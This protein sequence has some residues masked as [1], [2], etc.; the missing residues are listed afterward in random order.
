[1][2]VSCCPAVTRTVAV[3]NAA[4]LQA[5]LSGAQLGDNIVLDAGAT[6]EGNFIVSVPGGSAGWVTVSSSAAYALPSPGTRVGPSDAVHMAKIMSPSAGDSTGDKTR[7]ALGSDLNAT[8]LAA[9]GVHHYRFIGIEFATGLTAVNYG[10]VQF[11]PTNSSGQSSPSSQPHDIIF[12]RCLIHGNDP[13]ATTFPDGTAWLNHGVYLDA[14]NSAIVDSAVYNFWS[15]SQTDSQ[16]IFCG[17]G[18]GPRL[19]QNTL[20]SGGTE[21][22]LCGGAPLPYTNQ[23][24]T[25]ITIVHNYFTNPIAWRT[26]T[27]VIPYVKNRFELKVGQRVRITD[28][29]FEN[30][31]DRGNGQ[32]GYAVLLTPRPAQ[33]AN[34]VIGSPVLMSNVVDDI[35]LSNNVVRNVGAFLSTGLYDSQCISGAGSLPAGTPC[36]QSARL[37]VSD[38]MADYDAAI[39]P[40]SGLLFGFMQDF[41]VKRNTLLGHNSG[42]GLGQPSTWGNRDQSIGCSATFGTN[43]EFSYNILLQGVAGDCTFDPANILVSSWLG[44]DTVTSNLAANVSGAVLNDWTNFGHSSSIAATEASIGLASSELTLQGTSPYFGMGIGANLACFNEAA[45]RAGTPSALCPLPPEVAGGGSSPSVTGFKVLF[46]SQS[47]DAIGSS[48]TRLPWQITGI[49][50]TFSEPIT[51]GNAGSLAGIT[52]TG[53]SGL[54]TNT[55]T[56][57]F[58]PFALGIF[59]ANLA[60]TGPNALTDAAGHGLGSGAGFSQTLEVLWGDFNDDGS[61]NS[62]DQVLVNT[63]TR[64]PYNILADMNGDGVVNATDVLLVRSRIGTSLH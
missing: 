6:Y 4:D 21:G 45:I 7:A 53:F 36:A 35:V 39:Y 2:D 1:V 26:S 48:R 55:L 38:N 40:A 27:P 62:Q 23:I 14:A 59:T 17:G 43:F 41:S 16:A 3:H 13:I 44:T 49:Q 29:V 34:Y 11:G 22:W 51:A 33:D 19:L 9:L 47:Y 31:W 57:T 60:G 30:S 56:W 37:L 12:D 58:N 24:P 50:A 5:A 52:A 63:A 54:G 42:G 25:D 28:N 32:A 20:V 18:P 61:V 8:N 64:Y 10:V 15:N 46:G